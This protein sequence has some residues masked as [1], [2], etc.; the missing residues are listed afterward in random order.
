MTPP[1]NSN[2]SFLKDPR[3]QTILGHLEK[4]GHPSLIVGG[5]ARDG[6]RGQIPKDIDMATRARPE[7]VESIF[8]KVEGAS[9]HPTGVE[10]GTWTVVLG[11]EPYEITTFRRDV[12]TDGR[13]ATIA[14]S[15]TFEEDAQR[16]DFTINALGID[17][18]GNIFDPTGQGL[19]DLKKGTVRFVGNAQE[20]CD[21]DALRVMRL[22]RFQGRMGQGPMNEEAL[23][24]ARNTR[25]HHISGERIWSEMKGILI[26]DATPDLLTTM[27][28]TGVLEQ[29][30]PN[31]SLDIPKL[32]SVMEREKEGHIEPHWARR[33]YAATG[34]NR[35]P[36][37]MSGE[38]A[39][40]LTRLSKV[41]ESFYGNAKVAAAQSS[42]AQ[43]GLD[44][45]CLGT[46]KDTDPLTSAK[47]GESSKMPVTG[48]D[49]IQLGVSPGLKM[50]NMIEEAKQNWLEN[51]L[52]PSK[53]LLIKN[54][55]I[56]QNKDKVR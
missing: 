9:L 27:K 47:L 39:K 35:L 28:T 16:R 3:V 40:H 44:A 32:K 48:K 24:A 21:E 55:G 56:R 26:T 17:A 49:L 11:D 46:Q 29:I 43:T 52:T 20:R 23:E 34:K 30:L 15:D 4:N 1:K 54:L 18:R 45:W 50:G 31:S 7:E 53:D 10:H 38:E 42:S 6:L 12:D 51:D 8:S 22:F 5:A 13:R 25:L 41:P 37:P 2:L 36:Y 33:I 19:D 14:Y